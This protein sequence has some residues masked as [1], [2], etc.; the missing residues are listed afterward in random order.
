MGAQ[1]GYSI[2]NGEVGQ[3][4]PPEMADGPGEG[5]PGQVEESI[6]KKAFWV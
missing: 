2:R 4:G 6:W 1:S 5:K 3:G